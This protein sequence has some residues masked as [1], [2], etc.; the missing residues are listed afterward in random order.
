MEGQIPKYPQMAENMKV[1]EPQSCLREF[2]SD[3]NLNNDIPNSGFCIRGSL[4]G[5][6]KQAP[7]DLCMYLHILY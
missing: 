3:F 4:E 6:Q 2:Y 1:W 7:T 5:L